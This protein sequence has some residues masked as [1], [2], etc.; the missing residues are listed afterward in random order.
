MLFLLDEFG[1]VLLTQLRAQRGFALLGDSRLEVATF[2][3]NS[4]G[5]VET[6]LPTFEAIVAH[7]DPASQQ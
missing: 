6:S 3:T 2:F 4:D 1:R 7:S 5:L